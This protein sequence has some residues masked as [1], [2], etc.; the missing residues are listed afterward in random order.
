MVE[1]YGKMNSNNYVRS[2]VRKEKIILHI[3]LNRMELQKG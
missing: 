2:L 3:H 1:N